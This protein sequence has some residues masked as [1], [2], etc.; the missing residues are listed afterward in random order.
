MSPMSEQPYKILVTIASKFQASKKRD[1]NAFGTQ[2][3]LIW[4]TTDRAMLVLF[5]SLQYCL[6][7][8]YCD[9]SIYNTPKP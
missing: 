3:E 6:V 5:H 7:F 8:Y 4:K 2:S 9:F 1:A